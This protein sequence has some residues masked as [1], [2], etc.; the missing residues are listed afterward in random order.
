MRSHLHSRNWTRS[1]NSRLQP[2]LGEFLEAQFFTLVLA[3]GA[4]S[5]GRLSPTSNSTLL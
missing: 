4:V 3:L 1:R 2:R 5:V